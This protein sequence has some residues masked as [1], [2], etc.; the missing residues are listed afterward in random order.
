MKNLKDEVM[1]FVQERLSQVNLNE[2]HHLKKCAHHIQKSHH[3]VRD[4]QGGVS[5][6]MS[7]LSATNNINNISQN[8]ELDDFQI[9]PSQEGDDTK[10]YRVLSQ[11]IQ[12]IPSNKIMID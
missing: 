3:R 11:R 6:C 10:S 5:N 8:S 12:N 7:M 4:F 1:E 9:Q 2:F